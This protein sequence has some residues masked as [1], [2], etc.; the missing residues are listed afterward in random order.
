MPDERPNRDRVLVGATDASWGIKGMLV[1]VLYGRHARVGD[2]GGMIAGAA[3]SRQAFREVDLARVGRGRRDKPG[4]TLREV[5]P[6][7]LIACGRASSGLP[8]CG[9]R[10]PCRRDPV[11]P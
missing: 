11:R 3:R 8:R 6:P 10:L 5:E 2:M 7:Q 4:G 9:S 1:V